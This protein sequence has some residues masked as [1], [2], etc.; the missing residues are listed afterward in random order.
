MIT[1]KNGILLIA[2]ILCLTLFFGTSIAAISESSSPYENEV[3]IDG[4]W[5]TPGEWAD[6]SEFSN[7]RGKREF[8]YIL[9]KD[10]NQFLYVMIDYIADETLDEKDRGGIRLDP[11]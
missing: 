6:A 8:G 3:K 11:G 5:T 10:S 9:V 1:L 7:I 2:S 4:K